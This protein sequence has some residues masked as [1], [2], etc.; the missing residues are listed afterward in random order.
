MTDCEFFKDIYMNS[1][2]GKVLVVDD[3]MFTAEFTAMLLESSGF[4]T[5]IAE[6]GV[7]ALEKLGS[8]PLIMVVVSDMNMPFITGIELFREMRSCSFSHPFVLLT[9][10]NISDPE[11]YHPG[12]EGIIAKDENLEEHLP[13]LVKKLM[14]KAIQREMT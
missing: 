11:I 10:G 7:D 8:D 1:T 4:E 5:V 3:D 14:N 6:G 12:I 2:P 9:A 13:D